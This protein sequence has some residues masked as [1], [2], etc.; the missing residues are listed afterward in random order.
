MTPCCWFIQWPPVDFDVFVVG[1]FLRTFSELAGANG[2]E[3]FGATP[4][5]FFPWIP[6][7]AIVTNQDDNIYIYIFQG[8]GNLLRPHFPLLLGKGTQGN[9]LSTSFPLEN[10]RR[11]QPE[12]QTNKTY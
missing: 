7:D 2:K 6:C 8:R 1:N 5:M 3:R 9:P 10:A 11:L 4:A 12:G